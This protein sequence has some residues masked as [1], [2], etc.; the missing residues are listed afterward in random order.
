MLRVVAVLTVLNLLGGLAGCA[1]L[2]ARNAQYADQPTPMRLASDPHAYPQGQR[3]TWGGEIIKVRNLADRTIME[4][5]A[6]PLERNDRP[7]PRADSQGRFLVDHRGYLEPRDYGPGRIVTVT[8]GLLGYQDGTV[9]GADYRFPAISADNLRLW[10]RH[11][12]GG[13]LGRSKPRVGVGVN[14]GS[15]GG[16][17][18]V[19]VG[20]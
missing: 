8:G 13:G 18:G 11:S 9:G 19:N 10:G 2:G 20:F 4:V 14:V 5:L 1:N 3:L 12:E 16:S 7:N 17:V 6:Y 15:G